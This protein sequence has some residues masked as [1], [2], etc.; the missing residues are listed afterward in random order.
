MINFKVAAVVVPAFLA[1]LAVATP[2][3]ANDEKLKHAQAMDKACES[4]RAELLA[5][6]RE[7][8]AKEC[9][10]ERRDL[11]NAEQACSAWYSTYG[12]NS[13]NAAGAVRRGMFYNLPACVAAEQ[14]WQDWKSA[15]PWR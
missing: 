1:A 8:M 14:A 3:R 7:R 13:A 6:L 10:Q 11:P 4:A 5:P 15:Q 2:A 9:V 12:N